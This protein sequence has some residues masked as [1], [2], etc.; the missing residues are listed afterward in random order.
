MRYRVTSFPQNKSKETRKP[1]IEKRKHKIELG[2]QRT[3]VVRM[4]VRY[5]LRIFRY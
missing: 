2:K 5:S 1:S 4:E 3:D